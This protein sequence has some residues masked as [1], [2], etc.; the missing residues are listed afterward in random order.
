M[1]ILSEIRKMQKKL[2]DSIKKNGLN[3]NE[4]KEIS[5]KIDELI[6]EYYSS[7]ETVKFPPWSNSDFYYEKSYERLKIAT[8]NEQKFPSV[9]EWNKIAKEE[10]LFSAISMQYI[11]SLD[12]NHLRTKIER[13]LNLKII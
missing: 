1:K 2:N 12:W 9:E 4:T 6:N 11:T 3:S 8:L 13:E 10:N 5:L 7:V